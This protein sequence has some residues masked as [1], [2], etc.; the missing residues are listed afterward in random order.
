MFLRNRTLISVSTEDLNRRV[1]NFL[2]K[3]YKKIPRHFIYKNL[4]KGKIRINN[5]KISHKYKLSYRDI[6]S[7]PNESFGSYKDERRKILIKKNSATIKRIIYEDNHLLAINK[8]SGVP[9]HGGSKIHYGIIEFLRSTY[10]K[11]QFLELAHRLDKDTSGILLIAKKMSVLRNL[12]EQIRNKIVKKKYFA[13][14]KGSWPKNIKTVKLPILK[15]TFN[16]KTFKFKELFQHAETKFKIEK[17]FSIAT[18]MS[19][20]PVTGRTHQIR[21]HSKFLSHPIALDK[22]YGDQKF[23][24][25]LKKIGLKRL[26]LH[27]YYLRFFHP[28]TKK[29]LALVSPLDDNLIECLL[30]IK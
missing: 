5:L 19:V 8:P 9:V 23:N 26:F 21:L 3:R 1:D 4:R 20:E 24:K 14:V 7:L 27:S 15:K 6:I 28:N 16:F 17:N 25:E 29:N 18:L 2:F 13:L 22:S 12:H 11:N 30:R 10:P